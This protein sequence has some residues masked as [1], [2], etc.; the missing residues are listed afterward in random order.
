MLLLKLEEG[1]H[2]DGKWGKKVGLVIPIVIDLWTG[3]RKHKLG[4][5]DGTTVRTDV[6]VCIRL[7][8]PV[9]ISLVTIL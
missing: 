5:Y 9:T 3:L 4:T 1:M 6:D 2:R 7:L 8:I